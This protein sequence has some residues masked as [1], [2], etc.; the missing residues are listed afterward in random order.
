MKPQ[1]VTAFFDEISRNYASG[2]FDAIAG[3]YE[4]PGALYIEE[5]IVLWP[6]QSALVQFLKSHCRCNY[7]LGARSVRYRIVAQSL[8][9]AQHFSV[10]VEWQ[11][12]D[13]DGDVVFVTPARYFCRNGSDGVPVI[14]LVEV[15]QRPA[16]YESRGTLP[17]FRRTAARAATR[18][19]PARRTTTSIAGVE[20][21]QR[22]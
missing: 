7:D 15:P 21:Y 14:Q 11:H 6:N 22:A 20:W 19:H 9:V 4:L 10:W 8:K 3:H 13:G 1:T 16:C 2:D 12:L 5:D 18:T 17:P